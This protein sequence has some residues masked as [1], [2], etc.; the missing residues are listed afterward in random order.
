MTVLELCVA[1]RHHASQLLRRPNGAPDAS[2]V[3]N[4]SFL[5]QMVEEIRPYCR[6]AMPFVRR[7]GA[8]AGA[9]TAC[10]YP[11]VVAQANSSG[12]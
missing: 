9:R 8:N 4:I 3:L 5:F 7:T 10:R 11:S 2:W 6:C 1:E 12:P